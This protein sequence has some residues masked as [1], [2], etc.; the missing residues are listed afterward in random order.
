MLIGHFMFDSNIINSDTVNCGQGNVPGGLTNP[1]QV[2][3][4]GSLLLNVSLK[5]L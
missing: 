5:A 1:V 4:P 2:T 3:I